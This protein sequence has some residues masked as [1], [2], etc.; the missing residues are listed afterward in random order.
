M[1]A[2][3]SSFDSG[4][5]GLLIGVATFLLLATGAIIELQDNLNIIWKAKP[6]QT[7]GIRRSS[8]RASSASRSLSVSGSSSWCR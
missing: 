4:V 1:I 8:A 3:A 7:Y 6:D 5:I 2:S